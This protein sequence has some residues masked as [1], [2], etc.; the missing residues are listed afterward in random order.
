MEIK[1]IPPEDA[2]QIL[3]DCLLNTKNIPFE[4]IKIV[5]CNEN[6]KIALAELQAF[7]NPPEEPATEK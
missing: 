7:K 2:L 5:A 4:F 6:I 3:F 1:D